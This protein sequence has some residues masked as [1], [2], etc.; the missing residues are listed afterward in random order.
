LKGSLYPPRTSL[1]RRQS[2]HYLRG[3]HTQRVA[4]NGL[5]LKLQQCMQHDDR[6]PYGR[7]LVSQRKYAT[8][9]AK[10]LAGAAWQNLSWPDRLRYLGIAPLAVIPYTLMVKGLALSGF[11]GLQYT[12]QRVIAEIYLQLARLQLKFSKKSTK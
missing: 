8:Q 9:E 11:A 5:V 4:I 2:A 12:W 1:Y 7:W 10:K 6:K 3:G